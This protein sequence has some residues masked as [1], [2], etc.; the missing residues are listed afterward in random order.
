[1]SHRALLVAVVLYV[2]LLLAW[3]MTQPMPALQD[4][5]E[6]VFQGVAML[7]LLDPSSPWHGQ[8]AW[9]HMPVPNML[10]QLF[11]MAASW[12]A[13]PFWAA[14]LLVA[15]YCAGAVWICARAARRFAPVGPVPL[16]VLLL[17][18]AAFNSC[19]WHGY[20]NFQIALL[21][22]LLYVELTADRP[23]SAAVVFGFGVLLFCCHASMFAAFVLMV[24]LRE[25]R[26]S[27]RWRI[28]A[29]LT[30]SVGLLGFYLWQRQRTTATT[31]H[32]HFGSLA[33]H[34]AYKA[35]TLLKL[36]PFHNLVI[37]NGES[38]R[39]LPVLYAAGIGLNVLFSVC[40]IGALALGL[41]RLLQRGEL[42]RPTL[43]LW[44]ALG[45]LFWVMPSDLA[46]VVNLGERFLLLLMLLMLLAIARMQSRS[47]DRL[48]GAAAWLYVVGF[49]LT[50]AQL[51]AAS[52]AGISAPEAY[53]RPPERTGRAYASD[54]LFSH[55]LYQ[56]DE[57][58]I[59][60]RDGATQTE[61]LLFDTGLL[62]N[63]RE[64]PER[65]QNAAR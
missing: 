44:S 52:L 41:R 29:A 65:Y 37:A 8:Y 30:P 26:C 15:L 40:L 11:L 58:R 64:A 22:I 45:V 59:E 57:R 32:S 61:P 49:A 12:V 14:K 10:C 55:R 33:T 2:I 56:N 35:Y 42:P 34:M 17:G 6:W 13:G 60:L 62:V 5:G 46:E 16:F 38:A 9:V 21:L 20:M 24:P 27:D 4:L 18:I 63:L 51:P 53:H 47:Q 43:L 54:G 31:E 3:M 36:G 50:A 1:M 48:L 23:P 39:R 28:V 7:R 19:F 25:W